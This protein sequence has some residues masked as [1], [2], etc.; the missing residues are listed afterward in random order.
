[1]R[2][3]LEPS[4]T[5]CGSRPVI[6]VGLAGLGLDYVLLSL[7]PG[8]WWLV[9][10]RVIARICGATITPAGTYIAEVSPPEKRPGVLSL[11]PWAA[12]ALTM[13]WVSASCW[14][15][16]RRLASSARAEI[17]TQC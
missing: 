13:T 2:P 8:I 11:R 10:R 5:A 15:A 9:L 6:L 17:S 14:N 1:M 4:P 12:G 16:S 3:F 7:A